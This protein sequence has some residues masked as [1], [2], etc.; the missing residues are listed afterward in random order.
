MKK[1]YVVCEDYTA[2]F[3]GVYST[4]L[5]AQEAANE[6]G[7]FVVEYVFGKD[8]EWHEVEDEQ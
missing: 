8:G 3:Y 4:W 7:G 5:K 1:I 6:I 2:A